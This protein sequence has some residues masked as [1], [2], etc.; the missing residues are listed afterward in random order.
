MFKV[1]DE[2]MMQILDSEKEQ[3]ILPLFRLA[4][5][6]FFLA[7]SMLSAVSMLLWGGFWAGNTALSGYMYS[8]PIWW[9][10]HEMLFGFT[11]A[12]IIGFLLTA[13]QN[14]T[15]NP[16][17][18]GWKLAVIFAFWLIARLG[19]FT[20]TPH[21]LWMVIDLMWMP[22]AAGFLAQPI[23]MR[24]QWNNLFFAPLI[25]LMTVLNA[26]FHLIALGGS[27]IPLRAVSFATVM[28]ISVIVLVVGGRVIPFFT[29]R[30][31]HTEQ[32]TRIKGL[33]YGALVPSWLLLL[34]VLLPLP[35]QVSAFTLPALLA[36]ASIMHLIRFV[37]WRTLSTIR[38]P[39]LWLLHFAYLAMIVGMLLLAEHYSTGRMNYSIALHIV[40]VGGIGC[41]ILAMIARVSL[42]HTGRALQIKPIIVVA[43]VALVLATL[44]RTLLIA[45]Q[46]TM[47]IQGYIISAGL[48]ALAFAIFSVVYCPILTQPRIDGRPG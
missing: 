3:K 33:E 41:M 4:F 26:L 34:N 39:L 35:E 44:S 7:A 1:G 29:W 16:G 28:V 18:R 10:S 40:T 9:H 45:L 23:I 43:F 13:V 48:W 2:T 6:P 25:V 14:W 8:N 37:R 22:L 12:I 27:D 11:G 31:T 47:T 24:R 21:V 20:S 46:P 32:I 36:V 42:G 15:G 30:G 19:M 5:R 17:V 38:V